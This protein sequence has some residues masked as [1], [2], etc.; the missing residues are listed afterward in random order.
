MEIIDFWGALV[1]GIILFLPY[2]LAI[3]VVVGVTFAIMI[4]I[5][6]RIQISWKK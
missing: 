2:I 5:L 3:G 4:W 6:T 1:A